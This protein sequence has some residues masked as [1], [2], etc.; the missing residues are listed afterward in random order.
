MASGSSHDRADRWEHLAPDIG[1]R[2]PLGFIL[3]PETADDRLPG[4]S[5]IATDPNVPGASASRGG[6]WT[7]DPI[8][9]LI[10]DDHPVVADG[11]RS[12]LAGEPGIDVVGVA[13]SA[14]AADDLIGREQP[15][16]VVCDVEIGPDS[17]FDVLRRHSDGRREAT[18]AG[19]AFVMFSAFD[20][21]SYLQQAFQ[22]GALGYVV[23]G[24]SGPE[25]VAAVRGAAR[26][27]HSFGADVIRAVRDRIQRPSERL[28]QV[29]GLVA[30]GR[31]N[32][33]LAHELGISRKTVEG[34][35]RTLFDR[36]GV[37]SRTELAMLAVR[38]GWIQPGAVR[39]QP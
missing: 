17:G 29:V 26:G 10:V 21:R 23:K 16:V 30:L 28:L 5:A 27:E 3:R 7:P 38:E 13:G 19:P 18:I 33:E 14:M 11:V 35:V 6:E 1:H 24:A 36:Y 15:D 34:H 25:L 31:T 37:A 12:L 20:R 22:D 4:D 9:V 2:G 8:R 39:D 32:D